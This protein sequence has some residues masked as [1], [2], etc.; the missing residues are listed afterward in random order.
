MERDVCLSLDTLFFMVIL[1]ATILFL[2]VSCFLFTQTLSLSFLKPLTHLVSFNLIFLF[3]QTL[4]LSFLKLLY[5]NSIL[6]K[7]KNLQHQM[8]RRILYNICSNVSIT[9]ISNFSGKIT[10][11]VITI[12]PV[13]SPRT[14]PIP[15]IFLLKL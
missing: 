7:Y 2:K 3:T 15:G 6:Q 5:N 14:I 10:S 1:L 4:S 12:S 8:N 11:N 9:L 13:C